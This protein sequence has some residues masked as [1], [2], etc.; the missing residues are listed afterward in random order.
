MSELTD[1]TAAI[2]ALIT[3]YGQTRDELVEVLTTPADGGDTGDGKVE[4]TLPNGTKTKIESI[5][6]AYSYIDS[7][8]IRMAADLIK[9]QAMFVRYMNEEDARD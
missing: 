9:L 7:I 6:A 5:A 8:N 4:V 2:T 3:T 1:A